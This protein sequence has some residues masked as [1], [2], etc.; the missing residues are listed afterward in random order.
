MLTI[1][2]FCSYINYKF[3]YS[4]RLDISLLQHT[5]IVYYSTT[6]KHLTKRFKIKKH[7]ILKNINLYLLGERFERELLLRI[8]ASFIFLLILIII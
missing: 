3:L 1:Q 5:L 4:F 6:L 2:I 7:F 8:S